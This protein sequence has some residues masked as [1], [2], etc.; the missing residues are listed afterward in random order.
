MLTSDRRTRVAAARARFLSSEPVPDSVVRDTVLTS[1]RRCRM[2]GVDISAPEVPYANDVDLRGKLVRCASPVLD[3]L[4]ERLTDLP[5]T[6]ALTDEK[7]RLL[8]RRDTGQDLARTW[9]RVYFAPGFSYAEAHAGTNG[10]G[11]ALEEG[12]PVFVMGPEHFTERS[13]QFACAGAPIRNPLTRRIE[14]VINLS[15]LTEYAHPM[16]AVLAQEAAHDIEQLLLEDG[17]ER[18][19]AVL[20]TFLAVS[21][22]SSAAVMAVCG[23]SVMM[24]ERASSLLT[25]ADQALVRSMATDLRLDDPSLPLQMSLVDGR[26]AR[27]HCH[28]VV[29]GTALAGAVFELQVTEARPRLSPARS[30]PALAL[31]GVV[32]RSPLWL[33]A[34]AEARDAARRAEPLLLIGEAGTGK[35]ALAKG[36]HQDV[37]TAGRFLLIECDGPEHPPLVDTVAPTPGLTVVLRHL[38]R[39]PAEHLPAVDSLLTDLLGAS[40]KPWVVATVGADGTVPTALLHHFTADATVPPLRHRMDDLE[41]LVGALMRRQAPGRRESCSEDA[42]R[43]LARNAWPGNVAE[44]RDVLAAAMRQRPAGVIRSEDLPA[45]CRTTSRRVLSPMEALERDAIVRA[46]ADAGGNKRVAAAA[47]GISRSSLYRKMHTYG[48]V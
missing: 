7:G 28:P 3:R 41:A 11:T 33:K 23:D 8:D 40:P 21:R 9:D 47:L 22:R 43:V 24:N 44:L 20:G 30:G 17:S 5:V 16:M 38:D 6:A 46:L 34:A 45:S 14:G 32:G 19:R 36:A 13:S 10:V 26:W 29:R 48:I 2:A 12:R 18:Q 35:L 31:P 37:R 15:C 39:L 42:M 25:P 27:V 4:Q 1:W